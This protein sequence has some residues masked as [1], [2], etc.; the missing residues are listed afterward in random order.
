[1][2]VAEREVDP[3]FDFS[4]RLTELHEELEILDNEA[5]EL[6]GQISEDISM[7]LEKARQ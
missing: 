5:H 7:L 4:E 1:V 6:E 3:D 2:G